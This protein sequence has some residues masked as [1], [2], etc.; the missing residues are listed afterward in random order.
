[1]TAFCK[2]TDLI[3]EGD[4]EQKLLFPIITNPT[5]LGLGYLPSD[6]RTKTDLKKISIGKGLTKKRYFPDYVL[7]YK[8]LPVIVIEAKTPGENLEE[9]LR[10][11]RLYALELNAAFLSGI[12]PCARVIVS[13]GN[14][15]I[16]GAWDSQTADVDI[17]FNQIHSG[18]EDYS[19]FIKLNSKEFVKNYGESIYKK[20]R[21]KRNFTR[22]TSIL[23]GENVRK[24]EFPENGF[25]STLALEYRHLFNPITTEDRKNIVRHAYIPS[26]TKKK[27]LEPIN[28]IILAARPA[29][30]TDAHLIEDTSKPKEIYQKIDKKLKNELLILVG[31]VGSG[32]STFTDYLEEVALPKEVKDKT[33]WL[34]LDLN[35]APISRE[36]IYSWL[37][38]GIIDGFKDKF[39]E[40]DFDT[41]FTLKKLYSVELNK[42][43]KGPAALFP[44]DSEKYNELIAKRLT[45]LQADLHATSKAFTR[46][47]CGERDNKL[48][49]IVLDNCDKRNK[50]TQLLMF[51]VANWLKKEFSSL[52][53]L[54]IRDTTYDRHKGEP[55]LDTVIKD[56]VFRIDPPA[57]S[58]VLYKRIKYAIAETNESKSYYLGNGIK[59]NY[60]QKEEKEYLACILKSLFDND[61]FFRQLVN[62]IAGRD[63]RRG[64]EIFLDFCKSGHITE[65]EIL[66][67]RASGG[68]YV[69]PSH[70]ITRVLLRGNRKYYGDENSHIKNLFHSIPGEESMPNPFVRIAILQWLKNKYRTRGPNQT[71]GYHKVTDILS[72]LIPLGYS[73]ERILAEIIT[74]VAA[75]CIATESQQE[76]Y[77]SDVLSSGDA[78]DLSLINPDDLVS[79]APAGHT[80]LQL[81]T[82]LDYLASCAE[83]VWYEELQIAQKIANRI[84]G[85]D[86][87]G[88]FS[89]PS[90]LHNAI[91]LVDYLTEYQ[92]K[93][94]SK[95][96]IYLEEDKYE[97]LVD[98]NPS[99]NVV[100]RTKD[101][102]PDFVDI[103]KL[104]LDFPAG[105]IVDGQI[106][107]KSAYGAFIEF[108][109][110]A[111]GFLH[112]SEFNKTSRLS[113]AVSLLKAQKGDWL[114]VQIKTYR[115]EHKKF[116]L[117]LPDNS[118]SE[119]ES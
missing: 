100:S 111:V 46:Y 41:I 89:L 72:A 12:N 106:I 115:S 4:V 56:L 1:M 107:A 54:P 21:G 34:N 40:I 96:E 87:V 15:L 19:Q 73:E 9:A 6:F 70:L 13:D 38:Q 29:S 119:R 77:L 28:K 90:S 85:K 26:Q 48:F 108:G 76:E 61:P 84:S 55:P 97:N 51:E 101:R 68:N 36:E 93:F 25:G 2:I 31:N 113:A 86:G 24:E 18:S 58:E 66:K 23:G 62:G 47:L 110:H 60:K 75:R 59:V 44:V 92:K 82:N 33:V 3:S 39:S 45:E 11:A 94:I 71:L 30:V 118:P 65:E 81:L 114:K 49:V 104:K 78:M 67:L 57:L 91:D 17:T 63:V 64:I 27:H 79:I 105:M 116:D 95:P 7:I 103:E 117:K 109:L 10:E 102:Y 14:R 5:P 99:A 112:I 50:E 22:P 16:S 53:F 37:Y 69:L 20:I 52:V 35:E 98:L 83:D 43:I 74:L 32:K 42:V 80:H 88:H 8:G